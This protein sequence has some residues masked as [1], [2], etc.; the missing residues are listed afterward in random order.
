MAETTASKLSPSQKKLLVIMALF[1]LPLLIATIWYKLAPPS[2]LPHAG[3]NNGQLINPAQ[4]IQAFQQV[5]LDGKTWSLGQLETKWTLVHLLDAPC[6]EACSKSLYNTR[7]IRIALGKDMERVQ[8][9]V[10]VKIPELAHAES[11]MWAS[12]PDLAVLISNSAQDLAAQIRQQPAAP[13]N[14][15]Y[16]IDPLGN[17]MMSFSPELAPKLLMK[18]LTKLLKL[19]HIG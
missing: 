15:V 17:L 7:Q 13:T 2:F 8:R 6:N 16:L 19:S 14:T 1:F 10:V 9:V 4:R 12:H 3:T 11:K 18:D 5:T